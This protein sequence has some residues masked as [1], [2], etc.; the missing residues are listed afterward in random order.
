MLSSIIEEMYGGPLPSFFIIRNN[1]GFYKILP[2]CNLTWDR[3][4]MKP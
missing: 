4:V 1:G 3:Q 2:F